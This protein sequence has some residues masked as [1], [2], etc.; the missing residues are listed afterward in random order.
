MVAISMSRP[1]TLGSRGLNPSERILV[2]SH[3]EETKKRGK[4]PPTTEEHDFLPWW[5][6]SLSTITSPLPRFFPFSRTGEAL[7]WD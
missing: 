6:A 5:R 2:L 1:L 7:V 3:G 4:V